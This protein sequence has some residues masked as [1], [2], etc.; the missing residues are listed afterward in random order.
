MAP[1]H[2]GEHAVAVVAVAHVFARFSN[3]RGLGV[4]CLRDHFYSLFC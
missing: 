3:A 4:Q 1:N 2:V